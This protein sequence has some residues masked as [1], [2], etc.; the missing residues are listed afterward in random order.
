MFFFPYFRGNLTG[1]LHGI[2][3]LDRTNNPNADVIERLAFLGFDFCLLIYHFFNQFKL[4][5][6]RFQALTWEM[7]EADN[8]WLVAEPLR[9]KYDEEKVLEME[10]ML[11]VYHC[12]V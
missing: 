12:C 4:I 10:N 6:N 3:V 11:A 7:T 5:L 9:E 2:P 1:P 8:G